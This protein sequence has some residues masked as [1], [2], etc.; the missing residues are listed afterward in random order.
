[1]ENTLAPSRSLFAAFLIGALA[2]ACGG[3]GGGGDSSN[4][5]P[6]ANQ[7]PVLGS[8]AFATPEDQDL[9][10][11]LTATDANSD[12][13]TFSKVSDPA[14]G[15]LVSFA[16][17]GAFLYRPNADVSGADS[18]GISVSDGRG[19]TTS[20]TVSVSVT[21][22]NDA[23]RVTALSLATAEDSAVSARLATSDP[24]NEVV[25]VSKDSDP[26]SG[27][28]SAVGAD[29]SFTYTPNRDFFGPDSFRLRAAD[30]SGAAVVSTVSI[31]ITP[32]GGDPPVASNDVLQSTL[33]AATSI[34]VL[35]NDRDPDLEP[36]TVTIEGTPFVGTATVNGDNTI[37]LQNLPANFRGF[38][39]F[40]YR[41]TDPGGLSSVATAGVF[42]GVKPMRAVFAAFE[43]G[44]GP[45]AVYLTDFVNPLRSLSAAAPS[46]FPLRGF[47]AS[48]DGSA[49]LHDYRD[50]ATA[51][52]QE[53]YYQRTTAGS[54]PIRL[55]LPAG[56][57]RAVDSDF[58]GST[59]SADGRWVAVI[60]RPSATAAASPQGSLY[61]FDGANPGT[62]MNVAVPEA[63][64]IMA[65]RFSEDSTQLYFV[66]SNVESPSTDGFLD[67]G[68]VDAGAIYRLSLNDLQVRRLTNAPSASRLMP[69]F[70]TI[71]ADDSRI[72]FIPRDQNGVVSVRY[73][74][75]AQP[76]VDN[77]LDQVLAAG[78]SFAGFAVSAD[79]RRIAYG[80]QDA[81]GTNRFYVADISSTPAPRLHFTA[82]ASTTVQVATMRPDGGAVV[83]AHA[84]AALPPNSNLYE[85]LV[86]TVETE[87]FIGEGQ[88]FTFRY[89]VAGNF[90]LMRRRTEPLDNSSN[91]QLFSVT[92]DTL[93]S[94]VQL[95]TTGLVAPHLNFAGIE[96]GISILGESAPLQTPG[97]R[98]LVNLSLVNASAPNLLL[99]LSP[100]NSESFSV[101]LLAQIVD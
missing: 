25:T 19:G 13:L 24:E 92:R 80:V 22:V 11:Q 73:A 82:P 21:P 63:A 10:G 62:L 88:A 90:M 20:G 74:D 81:S 15:T 33:A 35:A 34:T 59:L 30:A 47:Q 44:T 45:T 57:A 38:T 48:R 18:F 31:N 79:A 75:T 29:G 50:S 27:T 8:I 28:L 17:S 36:L 5:P 12:S 2:A 86:G 6:P 77:G 84:T 55:V 83:Y 87:A 101:P 64:L 51:A 43:N 14:R 26:S 41:V 78:E 65:P 52:V 95:G 49:L 54:T 56:I 3:G 98:A 66:G 76:G 72:V 9:N 37:R 42:V 68:L 61:L 32:V 99:P 1:M 16:G 71:T 23:P 60:G 70:Y 7:P 93:G 69:T 67:R 40:Q 89:D 85:K 4:P 46:L 53:M 97:A 94:P 96:R 91:R 39:R 100:W 58:T